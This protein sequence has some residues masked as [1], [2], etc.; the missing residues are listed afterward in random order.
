M[1]SWALFKYM[2]ITVI[3]ILLKTYTDNEKLYYSI[4]KKIFEK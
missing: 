4:Y 3:V 2:F 1:M